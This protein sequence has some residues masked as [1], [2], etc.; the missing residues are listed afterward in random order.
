MLALDDFEAAA[1]RCLPR[2]IFGFVAGGAETNAALRAN[3]AVW[4]EI[5]FVPRTLVDVSG[6]TPKTT[7]FGRTYD[8]PFGLAPMG[9]IAMAAYQG[10]LVL[11]RGGIRSAGPSGL[12]AGPRSR[13]EAH[14]RQAASCSRCVARNA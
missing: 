9:L 8:A 13:L 5:A 14:L 4:D 1:R 12:Q 3:R 6:R 10:D 2:P 11:A 7:L